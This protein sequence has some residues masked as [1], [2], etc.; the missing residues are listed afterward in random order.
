MDFFSSEPTQAVSLVQ[1]DVDTFAQAIASRFIDNPILTGLPSPMNIRPRPSSSPPSAYTAVP[2]SAIDPWLE[3]VTTLI[4]DIRPH[5][6]YS[7]ARIPRAISL[8]VPSTLL[9]RPLFSLQRLSAMLPSTSARNRF[10]AWPSA[11]RILVY[12]ADSLSVAD[13]SNIAGLLRKFKSDG[14]Q[15]ELAWLQGGFQG[16]WR[17]RRD[18]VDT[19]PPTPDPENEEEEEEMGKPS[20]PSVL[21]TRHLPMSAFSLSSTTVHNSPH[22][23]SSAAPS[24]TRQPTVLPRPIVNTATSNS[25]PAYNPFFDTIRQNTELSH[26]ITERI[27]LRLPRRVRRRIHE[28]PFRWLQDIARRAANAAPRHQSLSDSSSSESEDDDGPCTVDIEEGKE[29]LAMQFFK[30]ELAEQ[31]RLMGIMEHHSKESGQLAEAIAQHVPFPFSITAGVEKGAKNRYRHIWPFE[32]A[33]V[34]LHQKKLSDDDYVNASYVQPLGTTK[35]YIATQGPLPATFTD[36]WT[37]CWEQNVHVIVML[38]REIEGAMVKC[39]T[40]WTDTEF[41]PLRLRLVSEEGFAPPVDERPATAGFFTQQSSL[42]IRQPDRKF[43]HSAGSQLRHR[44]R[45]YHTDTTETVKRVFELTHTGYPDAKPRKIVHL[46]YLE[47][48]DMNVPEDPRGVLGLIKQV[49]AAVRETR[50]NDAPVDDRKRKNVQFPMSEID[51]K[52]G[53]AKHAL[54]N[55][56]PVLL[57]CSAGVGRTGG[58][59]A[60]DAILDAIRREIRKDRKP[61]A[62]TSNSTSNSDNMDVDTVGANK[63]VGSGTSLTTVP[64]TISSGVNHGSSRNSKGLEKSRSGLVV[65]VPLATPMQV[66]TEIPEMMED[67]SP[68]FTA[69]TMQWAENV[70][71]ETGVEAQDTRCNGVK[72]SKLAPAPSMVPPSS[73]SMAGSSNTSQFQGSYHCSSSSLETSVSGT[74]SYSKV[75]FPSTTN[76][77]SEALGTLDLRQSV[78]NAQQPTMAEQR[79]R[80]ISA[81]PINM[82]S[83]SP[84]TARLQSTFANAVINSSPLARSTLPWLRGPDQDSKLGKHS[85]SSPG[86]T[87]GMNTSLP[88]PAFKPGGMSSDGEPP[89][90]SESPSADEA[91]ISQAPPRLM[92][93]MPAPSHPLFSTTAADDEHTTKTFDYKEPRPLHEDNSPPALTT[94]DDP[95]WEVVQD[96]REQR[97]SLCQSLRQYVFVHAAIIEGSLMVLDEERDIAEGSALRKGSPSADKRPRNTH[98][99]SSSSSEARRSRSP[100]VSSRR[101]APHFCSSDTASI[102]SN[103]RGASPTE[104]LKEDK[105]GEVMLSKRPSIKRKH[106]SG[107]SVDGAR[108][109]PVPMHVPG[110]GVHMNGGPSSRAMPP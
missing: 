59:I 87:R 27:P 69:G 35:R 20:Q 109:H 108:Y 24:Q 80:T 98:F 88:Q 5:A 91:S 17:E 6:A 9:K 110:G 77:Q 82:R 42:A 47:W 78:L 7:S 81:P 3:D 73:S 76:L 97:M 72:S 8:S 12:D 23:N 89:S 57:H 62:S 68:S 28:L 39:G 70:R 22:F 61:N 86:G 92:H 25:H 10:S 48:P 36:F 11:S 93:P 40:Y 75:S 37:L 21:R 90:R 67:D 19:H 44:P 103:K 4:V 79:A 16:L 96:M 85:I 102:T 104:L 60:V 53:I 84:S 15:G 64:L 14:F 101:R 63:S 51:E 2:P 52:V 99:S 106:R 55:N 66:D 105:A 41:G 74:S 107:N 65:H 54:G 50:V 29:A 34:R 30:I 32:H 94:F 31:R 95:I 1:N 100:S 33:R 83:P 46:Q 13:T 26:G 49:D 45:H 43:P 58:F 18:V 38:T 56:S 71:D